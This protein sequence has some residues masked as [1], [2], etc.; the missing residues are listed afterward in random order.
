MSSG[1]PGPDELVTYFAFLEEVSELPPDF[2]IDGPDGGPLAKRPAILFE[3]FFRARFSGIRAADLAQLQEDVAQLDGTDITDAQRRERRN[4]LNR[5]FERTPVPVID[6][7]WPGW[8]KD[9]RYRWQGRLRW[10]SPGVWFERRARRG[11]AAD[12]LRPVF[13]GEPEADRPPDGFESGELVG[14]RRANRDVT[15]ILRNIFSLNHIPDADFDEDPEGPAGPGSPPPDDGG[16][17]SG[18]EVVVEQEPEIEIEVEIEPAQP[19]YL[20][21]H[22]DRDDGQQQVWIL[23]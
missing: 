11:G 9:I 19:D 14:M 7:F 21:H 22:Q 18:V 12:S 1:D 16:T 6:L 17:P 15:R 5:A 20:V 23:S 2:G 4:Q 3:Q 13:V 10:P 8:D